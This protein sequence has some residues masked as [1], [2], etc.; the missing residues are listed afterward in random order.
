MS[1]YSYAPGP[2]VAL[3]QSGQRVLVTWVEPGPA[4]EPTPASI[5]P[6][7]LVRVAGAIRAPDGTWT[8]VASLGLETSG[9]AQRRAQAPLNVTA[10]PSGWAIL[11]TATP[12]NSDNP[13]DG[14]TTFFSQSISSTGEA[15]A[16]ETVVGY[17]TFVDEEIVGPLTSRTTGQLMTPIA[18]NGGVKVAVRRD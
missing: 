13:D 12:S 4:L 14:G 7:G 17:R 2:G 15:A 16:S 5:L 10:T 6:R 3:A 1:D 11:A 9:A 18:S 8:A